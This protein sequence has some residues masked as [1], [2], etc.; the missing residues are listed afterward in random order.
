MLG[1]FCAHEDETQD[2]IDYIQS[3]KGVLVSFCLREMSDGRIKANFRSKTVDVNKLASAFGG[4]GHARA[5]G[6]SF[7]NTGIEEAEK[8]V[9]EAVRKLLQSI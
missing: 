3:V 6:C 2:F 8:K 9:G 7:E 1:E 4:G 5:A